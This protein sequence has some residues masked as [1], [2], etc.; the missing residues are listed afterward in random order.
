M[1]RTRRRYTRRGVVSV[2]S[3]MFLVLFGSLA[4]AMAIASQG[5][6]QT[7]ASHLHVMRALGA[8]ETGLDLAEERLQ[9]AVSCFVIER[10]EIDASYG[11]GLWTGSISGGGAVNVLPLIDGTVPAGVAD[12]LLTIHG[13]DGN[14]IPFDGLSSPQLGMRPAGVATGVYASSDWV[15]TP[16]IGLETQLPATGAFGP[17]FQITY[18][19]LANGTDVRVIV[20]GIDF[21][22]QRGGRPITRT[23]MRDFR[24]VK[25]V[26]HAVLSPSRIMIGKNV[27]VTGDLGMLYDAVTFDNGHPLMTRSD[28]RGLDP[29]LDAIIDGFAASVLANDVDGDNRLRLGHPVEGPGALVDTDGDGIPDTTLGDVTGDQILDEID[30]FIAHYDTNADGRVALSDALRDGTPAAGLAAEF[31]TG[32]GEPI[33]DD[34][35][36]LLDSVMPDRNGNGVWG[37]DDL[38]GDGEWDAGEPF[39]DIDRYGNNADQVLGYRDGVIDAKDMY[40][41]VRGTLAFR[42]AEPDW[43]AAQGDVAQFMAGPFKPE[44][45]SPA[46]EYAVPPDV[47]PDLTGTSFAASTAALRDATIGAPTFEEQVASNLGIGVGDLATYV[48]TGAGGP[49]APAYYRLDPDTNSDLLPDNWATAYFERAPFNSPNIADW[50]YRPVYENMLFKDCEIPEGNNGL[51][52][53]C[54]FVGV[55]WVRSYEDNDQVNWPLY[56][57]M[58]FDTGA[59]RPLPVSERIAITDPLE[60]PVDVLPATALP[61]SQ[62][63]VIP[64]NPITDALDKADFIMSDRPVNWLDLPDPILVGGRRIINTKELSNNIRFHDCLFIG[65]IIS[66]S[67]EVYTHMRN[68]LQFTGATRFVSEHPDPALRSDPAYAPDPA[69]LDEIEKSTMM[70]P[71]YS[72]DIGSFNSPPEQDVRLRGVIIAGVLDVRGNAS[73]KGALLLTFRPE[74]G[75]PPLA[76]LFGVAVGNPA[77]FNVTLGYFGPEDGDEESLDPETLPLHP[78]PDPVSGGTVMRRIVGFDLDGDGLP[79]VG[80]TETTAGGDPVPFWGYGRISIEFDP[81]MTLPDGIMLQVQ[82]DPVTGTYA[83]GRP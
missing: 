83:E 82:T 41:K 81:D 4:A 18:A 65:S 23:I 34:L 17:A 73:I 75:V 5:N 9:A 42:V 45:G 27:S 14:V 40:A 79:D 60:Y 20:T 49:G 66:D 56:G 72:V 57:R 55:T 69:D 58:Y 1:R 21:D 3:M 51:F 54:T 35:A 52:V 36:L 39:L 62:P 28:F 53:N 63:F 43:V 10:G 7:A 76:D 16:P 71:G 38:D 29:A 47:L 33:D 67:P 48:E 44:D 70:L 64:D 24:L 61:P 15:F 32:G 77:D 26:D 30:L 19:P 13:W 2:L 46:A 22:L 37:F 50:Y 11:S 8:A 31:V 74:W 78:V 25:R 12:A 68:K 80:P 6:L 59:G